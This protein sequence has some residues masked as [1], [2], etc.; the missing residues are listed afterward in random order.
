MG[1]GKM[2]KSE[3]C[4]KKQYALH[5]LTVCVTLSSCSMKQRI[6]KIKEVNLEISNNCGLLFSAN[7]SFSKAATQA[8]PAT[9]TLSHCPDPDNAASCKKKHMHLISGNTCLSK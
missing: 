2:K 3:V 6:A 4:D 5:E 8:L 7:H 9:Q 1:L